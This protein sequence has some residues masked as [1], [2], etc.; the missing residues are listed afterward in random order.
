MARVIPIS[1]AFPCS[2][3][4]TARNRYRHCQVAPPHAASDDGG[5]TDNKSDETTSSSADPDF[6]R[7]IA[8]LT[9]RYGL[10]KKGKKNEYRRLRNTGLPK[11]ALKAAKAPVMLPPVPLKDPTSATGVPVQVGFSP[12]SE[13]INGY[14]AGLGLTA[15][16]LVELGSGQSV[17][18]YH[19]PGI[20]FLQIYTAASVAAVFVK[21]EKEKIS[22]WPKSRAADSAMPTVTD[23]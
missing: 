6:D 7:R 13:R 15:L 18:K 3:N 10:G 22:V 4:P 23:K 20:V 21:Y 5:E 8:E 2:L 11:S 9:S 1:N 12:Y 16:L 19:T 14:I 17:I